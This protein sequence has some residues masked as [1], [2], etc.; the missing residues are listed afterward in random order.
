MDATIIWKTVVLLK[1][2]FNLKA[3]QSIKTIFFNLK[4]NYFCPRYDW[5]FALL[6]IAS[7]WKPV[8]GCMSIPILSDTDI[9]IWDTFYYIWIST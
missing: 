5:L 8:I 7:T 3:K 1:C 9:S 4:E 6:M 2:I